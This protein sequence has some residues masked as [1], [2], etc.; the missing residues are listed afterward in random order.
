MCRGI[1]RDGLF[2]CFF[3]LLRQS[4]V[5]NVQSCTVKIAKVLAV[6]VWNFLMRH[7]ESK[8]QAREMRQKVAP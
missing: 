6:K 3:F 2:V 5:Y 1:L 8:C 7:Q 4:L